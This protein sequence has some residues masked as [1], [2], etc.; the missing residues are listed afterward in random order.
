MI[1]ENAGGAFQLL[2][3]R[4]HQRHEGVAPL[5]KSLAQKPCLIGGFHLAADIRPL[6]ADLLDPIVVGQPNLDGSVLLSARFAGDVERERLVRPFR[7][8]LGD[9]FP[10]IVEQRGGH[11][12]VAKDAGPFTEG[13]IC[14][15]DD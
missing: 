1:D 2:V 13:E 15:D 5:L 14:C 10:K 12:W 8:V 7:S 11:L 4:L 3:D 9:L 6:L